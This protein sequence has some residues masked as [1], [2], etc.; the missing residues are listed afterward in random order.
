MRKMFKGVAVV[1]PVL[2]LS[3]LA[4]WQQARIKALTAESAGLREQL[5]EAASAREES[6]QLLKLQGKSGEGSGDSPQP[7]LLRLRGEVGVLRRQLDEAVRATVTQRATPNTA[8][9]G[10]AAQTPPAGSEEMTAA[11]AQ[12][13]GRLTAQ[14]E[15]LGAAK[16][17]VGDLAATLGIPEDV[18]SLDVTEALGRQDL[19]SYWPYFEAKRNFEEEEKFTRVLEYKVAS[20]QTDAV[21]PRSAQ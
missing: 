15:E 18:L 3:S 2:A 5:A 17:K 11:V 9:V 1:V 20:E 10:S 14:K 21:I 16:Q 13:T 19:R 4:L 7:E 12:L 8:E 6:E